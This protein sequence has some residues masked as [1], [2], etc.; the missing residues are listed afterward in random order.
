MTEAGWYVELEGEGLRPATAEA[1]AW[2]FVHGCTVQ[3]VT[4]NQNLLLP[5]A[6]AGLEYGRKDGSDVGACCTI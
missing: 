4:S 3:L 2:A 5:V 1:A 6:P